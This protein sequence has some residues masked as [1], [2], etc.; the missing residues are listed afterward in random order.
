MRT[1]LFADPYSGREILLVKDGDRH[2]GVSYDPRRTDPPVPFAGDCPH[3][4]RGRL[5]EI[6]PHERREVALLLSCRE[7]R[8]GRTTSHHLEIPT[9]SQRSMGLVLRQRGRFLHASVTKRSPRAILLLVKE[10]TTAAQVI[11]GDPHAFQSPVLWRCLK[12]LFSRRGA[13]REDALACLRPLLGPPRK[14]KPGGRYLRCKE[15]DW[16]A[17]MSEA[18]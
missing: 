3:C 10:P 16:D 13:S 1:E 11:S 12:F 8:R 2:V 4:L 18:R 17:V 9:N 6:P 14:R 15:I 7:V 5:W